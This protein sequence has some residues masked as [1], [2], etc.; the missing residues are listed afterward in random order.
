MPNPSPNPSIAHAADASSLGVGKGRREIRPRALGE[1]HQLAH[2]RRHYGQAA[3]TAA[4]LGDLPYADTLP[5]FPPFV[6]GPQATMYAV[7]P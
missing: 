1:R 5:G 3:Y 4:D 6:R 2:A 7:K